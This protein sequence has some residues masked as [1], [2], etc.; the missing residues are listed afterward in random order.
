MV[1]LSTAWPR[2]RDRRRD[3]PWRP[4]R[5]GRGGNRRQGRRPL[6]DTYICHRDDDPRAIVG[7]D[8]SRVDEGRL[9]ANGVS[10]DAITIVEEEQ[11]LEVALVAGRTRRSALFFCEGIT[12]CWKQIIHFTPKFTV[13]GPEPVAK[14][15]AASAFRCSWTASFSR[16]MIAEF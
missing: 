12:R 5:R 14:R 10:P 13:P 16:R 6:H 7:S 2:G 1:D 3:V 9:I 8:D 15:L 11:V 4:A